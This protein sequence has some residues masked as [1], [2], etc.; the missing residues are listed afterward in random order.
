MTI[1]RLSGRV[2]GKKGDYVGAMLT[3]SIAQPRFCVSGERPVANSCTPSLHLHMKTRKSRAFP[4]TNS[5][6]EVRSRQP[7]YPRRATGRAESETVLPAMAVVATSAA[8]QPARSLA[9]VVLNIQWR[10]V[11]NPACR[12]A[13]ANHMFP[14]RIWSHVPVPSFQSVTSSSYSPPPFPRHSIYR[15]PEIQA[16]YVH[17][18]MRC[19][20]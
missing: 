9:S 7:G 11:L 6:N 18:I 12:L 19:V 5:R 17:K 2:R 15:S 3:R 8:M 16:F 20:L 4:L 14:R 1:A 13:T 10:H